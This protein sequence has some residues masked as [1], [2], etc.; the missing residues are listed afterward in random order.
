MMSVLKL[1]P[2]LDGLPFGT[3]S[4]VLDIGNSM[5]EW[6][7]EIRGDEG[8]VLVDNVLKH[9]WLSNKG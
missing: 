1:L 9:G 2:L 4:Q 5:A 7:G 3:R 8:V 6:D